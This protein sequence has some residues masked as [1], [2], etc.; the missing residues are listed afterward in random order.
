MDLRILRKVE[1]TLLLVGLLQAS[2]IKAR[3]RQISITKARHKDN[4]VK[5]RHQASTI[6]VHLLASTVL[7][8][9]VSMVRR[10]ARHQVN[11]VEL[12]RRRQWATYQDSRQT[13]TC[14][15]LQ[16]IAETR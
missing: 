7:L 14:H 16:M 12:Q 8:H 11:M 15:V 13:W 5:L 9:R 6:K 10:R 2:I 3:R 4:G 1:V